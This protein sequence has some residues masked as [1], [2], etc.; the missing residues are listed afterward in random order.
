[1]KHIK[2]IITLSTVLAI[3]F[4]ST[5][6][7]NA[8]SPKLSKKKKT[9]TVGK[10]FTLKVKNFKRDF[11]WV[12]SND[13]VAKLVSVNAKKNSVKIKGINPGKATITAK[14]GKKK[15]KCKVTVKANKQTNTVKKQ[16]TAET[17][18][19]PTEAKI[20]KEYTVIPITLKGS[21]Y[22]VVISKKLNDYAQKGWTFQAMSIDSYNNAYLIFVR[23]KVVEDS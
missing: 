2:Q 18:V 15:L 20:I 9:I 21:A 10:T 22:S 14:I 11:K 5:I 1:M 17:S 23:D 7:S 13:N 12:T 16:P 19:T 6:T 8:A 3:L 4:T